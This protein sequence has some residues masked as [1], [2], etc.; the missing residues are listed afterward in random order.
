MKLPKSICRDPNDEMFIPTALAGKVGTQAFGK[1][2]D[3]W[4][5]ESGIHKKVDIM[6]ANYEVL[7]S[8]NMLPDMI[9]NL[10]Y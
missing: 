7:K 2:G 5:D 10:E 9:A 8:K 4:V 6:L 1:P 3:Y